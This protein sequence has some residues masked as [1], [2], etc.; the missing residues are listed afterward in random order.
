MG[1]K[2]LSENTVL[3]LRQLRQRGTLLCMATGRSYPSIP[4]FEDIT[5]DIFLTFNGSYV[6]NAEQVIFT[7]PLDPRDVEIIV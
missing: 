3:A 5:F 7:N 2:D 6:K 1:C 4:H